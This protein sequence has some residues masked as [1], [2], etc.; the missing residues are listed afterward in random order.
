MAYFFFFYWSLLRQGLIQIGYIYLSF[1]SLC[2]VLLIIWDTTYS[3]HENS[4]ML[5]VAFKVDILNREK[6]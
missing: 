1:F 4:Y 6:L 2:F 3:S 5:S